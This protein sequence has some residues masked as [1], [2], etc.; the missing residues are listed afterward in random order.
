MTGHEDAPPAHR[1]ESPAAWREVDDYFTG[2][3]IS[4]DDALV[5]ARRSCA[6]TTMPN[7]EVAANQG[8]LLALLAQVSGARR[9][10]E[11]GTLA[12]Y[13][14]IWFAHAV[15]ETG[16]VVT[17]E[18]E[19]SNAA[20]A[21]EN[22]RRAGVS[23]RVEVLE[24]AAA[25]SAAALIDGRT[26]PFDLVFIDADKP[27][28]PRYLAA[29]MELTRPGSLIVIDNVVRNGA[30]TD[31]ASADPRVQGVRA[32]TRG[33]RRASGARGDG[34]P[35]GRRQ[36]LGR[37]DHRPPHRGRPR[38]RQLGCTHDPPCRR[39]PDARRCDDDR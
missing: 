27:N 37:A 16:R 23:D 36:G 2:A 24:G 1:Y 30:V 38:R 10:L 35:D 18:L 12:G 11:F 8:A 5:E 15:G 25:D 13:S 39:L 34:R 33:H 14:T 7:A 4:E 22:L 26:E 6:D 28:N 21:R 29:A 20:I 9:V 17:L 3:L 19:E 31:A 32:V